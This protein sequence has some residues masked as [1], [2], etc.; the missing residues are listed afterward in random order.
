M[1]IAFLVDSFPCLSETFILNQVTGLIDLGHDVEIFAA[2][3]GPL[4]VVHGD[5]FSY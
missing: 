4:E 3:R 5:V 1:R 2:V